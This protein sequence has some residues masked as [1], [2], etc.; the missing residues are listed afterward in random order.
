MLCATLSVRTLSSA[1]ALAV[2]ATSLHAQDLLP[3]APPQAAPVL[4]TGAAIYPIDGAPIQSGYIMFDKGAITAMGPEPAPRVAGGVKVVQ[5]AGKRVYPGL[6]GAM[7]QIGLTEIQS[8]RASTDTSEV[9]AITPEVCPAV[10]VNPDSTLIPVARANGVLT[11]GIAS[12]GGLIPGQV[13]VI[14]LDGW[15]WEEMTVSRSAG[16]VVNWPNVR[17]ISAPWMQRSADD[18]LKEIRQNLDQLNEVFST[19]AAYASAKEADPKAPTDLRWEALRPVFA[20]KAAPKARMPLSTEFS[21]NASERPGTKNAQLP[22]FVY[23]SEADQ[24]TSVLTWAEDRD[25]RVV[26]VGGRDAPACAD[27]LKKRDVPVIVTSV[28]EFPRRED[29][30]YDE[31]YTLPARLHA[32]GVRFCIAS[33]E[34]T[35]NERNLPYAA[36]MAVA[37]GLAHDQAL[38]AITLDAATI[39]G[40]G[41]KL[42]SLAAGKSATLIVTDGDPLEITTRVEAAYIDGREIDLSSK[43]SDLA[44][45][46]R[47]KYRQKKQAAPAR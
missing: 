43:Q 13:S 10:A 1:A 46:Y 44:E 20:P 42:G 26:I 7:T 3:K 18:Q 28:Y 15:T 36:G 22:L 6:V 33:G 8:V 16:M 21:G 29:S 2:A 39:L 34:E 45:K 27:L 9:G 31:G 40:V 37:H 32:A 17:P 25:L 47:E 24:I 11:V 12:G 30:P 4:I 5:G 14:R 19:A 35:A 41:D 38:R 23:A